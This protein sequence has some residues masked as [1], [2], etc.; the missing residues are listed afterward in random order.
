MKDKPGECEHVTQITSDPLQHSE[1]Y[2]FIGLC[3]VGD[4][5]SGLSLEA[6]LLKQKYVKRWSETFKSAPVCVSSLF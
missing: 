3:S 1:Q 2:V 4:D 5:S 6:N